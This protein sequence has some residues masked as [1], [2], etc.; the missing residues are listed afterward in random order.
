MRNGALGG[1]ATTATCPGRGKGARRYEWGRFVRP[2][3]GA[4][5]GGR[6]ARIRAAC[7]SSFSHYRERHPDK[8]AGQRDQ[9][10]GK[11]LNQVDYRMHDSLDGYT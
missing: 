9:K 10:K 6:P 5:L 7:R 4:R 3:I 1:R 2:D 11:A 8:P